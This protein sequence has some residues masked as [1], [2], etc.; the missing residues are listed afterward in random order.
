MQPTWGGYRCRDNKASDPSRVKAS[1]TRT[2]WPSW[3]A[4]PQRR[5]PRALK[6][7]AAAAEVT[8]SGHFPATGV[9]QA[10]G[11]CGDAGSVPRGV[12]ESYE[13]VSRC[14][15]RTIFDATFGSFVQLDAGSLAQ[16]PPDSVCHVSR[17]EENLQLQEG[18]GSSGHPRPH[19]QLDCRA[20]PSRRSVEDVPRQRRVTRDKA[21][22]L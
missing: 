11:I 21:G 12:P 5:A 7:R 15:S 17:G 14:W 6:H 8:V 1:P 19:G 16:G 22:L 9:H 3:R 18:R 10:V 2:S 13:S 20:T 4:Q